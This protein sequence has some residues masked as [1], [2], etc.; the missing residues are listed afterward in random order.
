MPL[1]FRMLFDSN[2]VPHYIKSMNIN[3]YAC[4][5][6]SQL[7]FNSNDKCFSEKLTIFC[8]SGYAY[9]KHIDIAIQ[10]YVDPS[11]MIRY[12]IYKDIDPT[13]FF[14]RTYCVKDRLE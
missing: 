2:V 8:T 13:C 1:F 9:H 11:L 6:L 7:D 3:I 14:V 12:C 4:L 5:L 10:S